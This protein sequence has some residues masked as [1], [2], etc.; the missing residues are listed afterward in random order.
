MISCA[1]HDPVGGQWP[2]GGAAARECVAESAP[3]FKVELYATGLD[4]PRLIRTAPNG[5]FFLPKAAPGDITSF[6][7]NHRRRQAGADPRLSPRAEPSVRDRVLSAGTESAVGLRRQHRLGR[8]LS[9]PERRF[10]GARAAEHIVGPAHRAATGRAT[11]NSQ[12]TAGRCSSLS[13]RV[14]TSTTPI[15]TPGEK[16]RAD[17]LEFNPDGSG[18]RVYA[19]GIRN[20]GG[21]AVNPKTGELWCSVN[22]RDALGRQPCSRLHHARAGGRF[23]WLAVVVHGRASGSAA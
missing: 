18:L 11:S 7:R 13:A 9:V 19:Y 21:M 22:E 15:R 23:L 2:E 20:R 17:I 14:R 16:N 4:N 3:G 10:E 1:L 6:P 8:A 12:P 5:D